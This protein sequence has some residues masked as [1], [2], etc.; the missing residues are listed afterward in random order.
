MITTL[1]D[2]RVLIAEPHFSVRA[3][4]SILM[5]A[6]E[7]M[8]KVGEVANGVEAIRQC[9]ELQPDV[10]LL[11]AAFA[12]IDGLDVARAVA[13]TARPPF[14]ILLGGPQGEGHEQAALN[15]GVNV[16]FTAQARGYD[17]IDAI[18]AV[19]RSVAG[20]NRS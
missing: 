14:I 16:Y 7:D 19:P 15:A 12:D 18:Q 8:Y 13:Q 6:F 2:I 11:G 1:R 5:S 10:L 17:V 9:V 4:L 3:S 20:I